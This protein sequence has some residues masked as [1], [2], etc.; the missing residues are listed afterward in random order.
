MQ[1]ASEQMHGVTAHVAPLDQAAS[2]HQQ[3]CVPRD[4]RLWS[5]YRYYWVHYTII[6]QH[7]DFELLGFAPYITHD[8]C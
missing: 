3:L 8:S 6:V 2:R 7:F 5:V 4:C 1:G